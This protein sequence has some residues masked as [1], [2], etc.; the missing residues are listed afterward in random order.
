MLS[1]RTVEHD[2]VSKEEGWARELG[3]MRNVERGNW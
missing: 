2:H 1:P 3:G